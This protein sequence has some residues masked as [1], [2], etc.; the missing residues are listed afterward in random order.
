MTKEKTFA[1]T[2][3]EKYGDTLEEFAFRLCVV[4]KTVE[5]WESGKKPTTLHK[6]L[7]NYADKHDLKLKHDAPEWFVMLT[8]EKKIEWVCRT[9]DCTVVELALKLG[10]DD[11]SIRRWISTNKISNV[12]ERL[13]CEF[14]VHPENFD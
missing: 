8:P 14:A 7:L 13:I 11:N 5:R 10:V 3:R 4:P 6:A 12:G 1:Q 2:V 9:V